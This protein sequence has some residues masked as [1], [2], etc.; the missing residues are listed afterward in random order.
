MSMPARRKLLA[1]K[2]KIAGCN[3]VEAEAGKVDGVVAGDLLARPTSRIWPSFR[4]AVQTLKVDHQVSDPIRTNAGLHLIALCGKHQ[5]GVDI[6]SRAEIEGR[7]Q[8]EQLGL[9]ARRY[10]RDLEEFGDDRNPLTLEAHSPFAGRPRRDRTRNR[11]QGLAGA[12]PDR[13]GLSGGWRL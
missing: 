9:V 10:L 13:S 7:I 8:D 5:S 4:D 1:L 11:H 2:S 6:P 3:D 12:A